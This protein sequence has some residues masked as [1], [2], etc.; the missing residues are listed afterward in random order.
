MTGAAIRPLLIVQIITA[1]PLNKDTAVKTLSIVI[2]LA[3][4]AFGIIKI[5]PFAAFG[6]PL[7]GET[8]FFAIR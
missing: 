4:R 3:E 1:V 5:V 2:I 6:A 8:F 7:L